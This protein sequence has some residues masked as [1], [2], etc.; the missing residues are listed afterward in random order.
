MNAWIDIVAIAVPL[1][2]AALLA[3]GLRAS[4][5]HAALPGLFALMVAGVSLGF[6]AAAHGQALAGV[7]AAAGAAVAT[8]ALA[9]AIVGRDAQLA[10]AGGIGDALLLDGLPSSPQARWRKFE[11]D[12]W[13]YIAAH[14]PGHEPPSD[15]A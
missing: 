3:L 9:A 7:T 13:A 2:A 15:D 8:G 5:P 6:V 1:L 11:R 4:L 12:L 14:S 10:A